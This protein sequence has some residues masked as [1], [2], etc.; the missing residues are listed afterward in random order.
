MIGYD[1]GRIYYLIK[2]V[3]RT[4]FRITYYGNLDTAWF[5]HKCTKYIS[6]TSIKKVDYDYYRI[7]ATI[8]IAGMFL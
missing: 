2:Y 6:A 4:I 3:P 7:F 8:I 1:N 5:S